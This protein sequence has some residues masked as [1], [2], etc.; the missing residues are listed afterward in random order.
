MSS[1][2]DPDAMRAGNDDRERVVGHLN[3]AFAEGRLEVAELDE[4]VA[5]AYAAKTLGELKPL[6]ADLPP[7]GT[8]QRA[9]PRATPVPQQPGQV[10]RHH[11]RENARR[12]VAGLFG[13]F[14]LNVVIWGIISVSRGD[15]AYFWPV[16]IL[17][18]VA[19]AALRLFGVWGDHGRG[20]GGH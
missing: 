6:T 10:D 1:P 13:L 4:R 15:L 7:A 18:P 14:V 20:H 17:V 12:A 5:A 9:A 16:W 8:V 3:G 2:V 11:D 19:M